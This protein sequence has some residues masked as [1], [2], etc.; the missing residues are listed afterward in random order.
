M[1]GIQDKST[2]DILSDVVDAIGSFFS[3]QK[4]IA[5]PIAVHEKKNIGNMSSSGWSIAIPITQI[6]TNNG[7]GKRQRTNGNIH[8]N[9]R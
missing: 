6:G 3:M 4:I 9:S 5:A 2:I 7:I 1:N 8:I